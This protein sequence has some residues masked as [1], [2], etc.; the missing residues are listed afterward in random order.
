LKRKKTFIVHSSVADPESI[1]SLDPDQHSQSVSGSLS[2][3]AK[4]HTKIEKIKKKSY[5]EVLDVLF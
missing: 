4:L 3:R 1:G 5:F 2:R